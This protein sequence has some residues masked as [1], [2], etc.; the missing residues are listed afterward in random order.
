MV[1]PEIAKVLITLL[2]FESASNQKKRMKNNFEPPGVCRWGGG[3]ISAKKTGVEL[4]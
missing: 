1:L 4:F 3:E 2:K